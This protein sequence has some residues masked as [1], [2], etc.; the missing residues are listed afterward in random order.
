MINKSRISNV[1]QISLLLA[2]F[3]GVFTALPA[4]ASPYIIYVDRN[5]TGLNNGSSWANAFTDL[6]VAIEAATPGYE[7]WVA[8][9]IYKPTP[10]I[11]RFVS[12]SLKNDIAIFG[13]FLGNEALQSDRNPQLNVTI[14]SGD[15]GE[16]GDFADNSI[17]VVQARNIN[18]T[19]I[20]DGF[21]IYGGNANGLMTDNV[22]AGMYNYFSSPTLKDLIFNQNLAGSGSAIHNYNSTPTLLNVTFNDY[23]EL[24]KVQATQ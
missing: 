8:A 6:Q 20:L 16:P 19:A 5:A 1:V 14:L 12:F 3:I 22:G 23:S 21:T 13:G 11:D 24:G 18:S 10:G 17:H 9:G 4:F 7:I 2:L 15:I